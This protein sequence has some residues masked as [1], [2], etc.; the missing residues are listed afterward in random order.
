MTRLTSLATAIREV[1]LPDGGRSRQ[2]IG[3]ETAR[4]GYRVGYPEPDIDRKKN[5]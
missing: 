2:P 3:G 4:A 1:I 5:L